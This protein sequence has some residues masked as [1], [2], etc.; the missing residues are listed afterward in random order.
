MRTFLAR[1]YFF[2][3]W[4]YVKTCAS[5]TNELANMLSVYLKRFFKRQIQN[6]RLT[7]RA[8]TADQKTKIAQSELEE[9]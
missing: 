6:S 3:H 9:T 4:L 8:M 1:V 5:C 2:M 7:N